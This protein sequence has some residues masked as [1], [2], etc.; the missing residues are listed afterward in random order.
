[1]IKQNLKWRVSSTVLT[2]GLL[3]G[4]FHLATDSREL[5]AT[6]CQPP[7]TDVQQQAEQVSWMSWLT[8][9]SSSYRFHYLDLLELLS[10]QKGS[11]SE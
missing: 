8:G 7:C 1:M 4:T 5:T 2:V 6:E 3:V 9:R 11:E 10:R